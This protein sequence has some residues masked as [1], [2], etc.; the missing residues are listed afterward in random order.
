MG[1]KRETILFAGVFMI[2]FI[3]VLL[4]I[5]VFV[6]PGY[7]DKETNI[8]DNVM[9]DEKAEK[10]QNY[11]DDM[12]RVQTKTQ[13]DNTIELYISML[14]HGSKNRGK[15]ITPEESPEICRLAESIAV[16]ETEFDRA[17]QIAD[18]LSQEIEYDW[19]NVLVDTMGRPKIKSKKS[20]TQVLE[21]KK[22]LCGELANTLL[23]MGDCL[24]IP[25]YTISGGG[26][27]WNAYVSETQ[28]IEIDTTQGCFDCKSDNS[29]TYDLP[30][31][32]LCSRLK[33]VS[34]EKVADIV[35]DS[36]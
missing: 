5:A 27:K 14:Q 11:I 19:G 30:V 25:I 2:L 23:L 22:G 16:G 28:I 29:Q 3:I 24:D 6:I 17:E 21:Q 15:V 32:R 4:V 31:N 33:C 1:T 10:L 12:R 9:G 18:Y 26:H 34:L 13:R 35:S 8:F 20:P 36:I 7:S